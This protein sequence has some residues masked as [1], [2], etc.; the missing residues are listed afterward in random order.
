VPLRVEIGPR[1][2]AA[3]QVVLA[4]R[5]PD[6]A[7]PRKLAVAETE[8]PTAVAAALDSVQREMLEAARARREENSHR[9]VR[10][11][12]EFRS[13]I[14]AEGGFVYA[15][16]CGAESCEAK[17]KEETKAEIRVIPD[18]EFQSPTAPERCLVCGTRSRMEVVWARAY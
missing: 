11:Y 1:D 16:W 7:G 13:R 4:R 2:V 17:A 10:D 9:D 8:A 15:G 3:G 14:E 6:A 18:E 12:D 5:V